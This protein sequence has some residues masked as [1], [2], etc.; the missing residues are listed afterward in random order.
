[1][2]EATR[3]GF[4][5]RAHDAFDRIEEHFNQALDESSTRWA[6]THC[7]STSRAWGSRPGPSR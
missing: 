4:L 5:M 3:A 7:T 1:M 6:L 2:T